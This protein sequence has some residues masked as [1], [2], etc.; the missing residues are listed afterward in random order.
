MWKQTKLLITHAHTQ[1]RTHTQGGLGT[2]G[3]D[4]IIHTAIISLFVYFHGA[5]LIMMGK[6]ESL[7][8]QPPLFKP[9]PS[10]QTGS[11]C[12]R[13]SVFRKIALNCL[14]CMMQ[15]HYFCNYY[16]VDFPISFRWHTTCIFLV[17][18]LSENI[19][20]YIQAS[21]WTYKSMK[22]HSL[23]VTFE[24]EVKLT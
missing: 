21:R 9:I 11:T 22:D 3:N 24:T 23:K 5:A 19:S 10:V 13:C 4:N 6:P 14:I 15:H 2:I 8:N 12:S 1:T 17:T 16:I 7:I 20:K 18:V